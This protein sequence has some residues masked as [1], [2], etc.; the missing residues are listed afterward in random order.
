MPKVHCEISQSEMFIKQHKLSYVIPTCFSILS[1]REVFMHQSISVPRPTAGHLPALSVPGWGISKFYTVRGSRICQP[2]G[3][4]RAFDTHV[5][6]YRN[7]TTYRILL[8]KQADWL[9]CQGLDKIV[10][11]CKGMSSILCIHFSIAYQARNY[12]AKSE[13][14]YA[15]QRFWLLNQ[16]SVDII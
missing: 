14:I 10:E 16:V 13:A 1:E 12:M 6:S 3:Y 9:I 2:R 11:G 15:N 4:H 7:I 5:V 8:E